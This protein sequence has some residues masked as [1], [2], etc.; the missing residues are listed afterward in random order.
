MR[1]RSYII[2]LALLGALSLQAQKWTAHMAYNHV[3][4]IAM[5]DECVY[6][7]SDGSLYSV[8]KQTE[9]IETYAKLSGTPSA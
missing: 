7:T 5:S 8:N 4:R 9:V 6:A 1:L 3:T 2:G